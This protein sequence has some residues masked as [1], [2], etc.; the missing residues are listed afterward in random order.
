MGLLQVDY[1]N[2]EKVRNFVTKLGVEFRAV[3]DVLWTHGD[4]N[5]LERL[6]EA[7]LAEMPRGGIKR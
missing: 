6:A 4:E 2:L 5:K 3:F 1:D 7:K